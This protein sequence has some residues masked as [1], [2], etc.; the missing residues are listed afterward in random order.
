LSSTKK[1][2]HKILQENYDGKEINYY[3][4]L[5]NFLFPERRNIIPNYWQ[6][7]WTGSQESY[8]DPSA[9]ILEI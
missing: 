4:G 7:K 1:S 2:W 6:P 8:I 5:F 9:R 3:N